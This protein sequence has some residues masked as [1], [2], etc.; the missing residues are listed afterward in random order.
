MDPLQE[1]KYAA[2]HGGLVVRATG[3]RIPDTEPVMIFRAQDALAIDTIQFY[4]NRLEHPGH[5]AAVTQRLRDFMRFAE[6]NPEAMKA[7][8]TDGALGDCPIEDVGFDHILKIDPAW[9]EPLRSGA[10]PY[11]LRRDDR[12]YEAGDILLLRETVHS[13]TEMQEGAELA[14]TGRSLVKMVRHVLRGPLPGITDGHVIL[15]LAGAWPVGCGACVAP[16]PMVL[17][18][19]ACGLQHIDA[20]EPEN[21]WENPPHKSHLCH[22]CSTVWRP[23]EVATTGVASLSGIG[24]NDT[25]QP[26]GSA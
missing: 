12:A 24:S 11:E 21:G 2:D 15:S 22:G 17:H 25:W 16:I 4:L 9:Y 10:K 5:K 8:D 7:P 14:Y 19:P 26:Q 18:C 1:P 20:P 13:A 6:A 3:K 23:A